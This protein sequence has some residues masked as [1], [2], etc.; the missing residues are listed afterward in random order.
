MQWNSQVMQQ[1]NICQNKHHFQ[2]VIKKKK[3]NTIFDTGLLR[4]GKLQMHLC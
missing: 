2:E 1:C 3:K 4:L